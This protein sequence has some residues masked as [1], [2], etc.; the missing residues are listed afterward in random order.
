MCPLFSFTCCFL[1][2]HILLLILSHTASEI[3]DTERVLEKLKSE[4]T[5]KDE[6][7]R[8]LRSECQNLQQS[9]ADASIALEK[10]EKLLVTEINDECRKTAHLL[11]VTPRKAQSSGY[12]HLSNISTYSL[13][14]SVKSLY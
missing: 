12:V 7:I 14:D 8:T 9:E 13:N 11:G 3:Q 2:F 10:L 6:E 5:L 1:Y 4:L